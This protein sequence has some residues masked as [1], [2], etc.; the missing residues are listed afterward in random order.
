MTRSELVA[1]L[2]Q[3]HSHLTEREMR[4]IVATLF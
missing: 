1:R 4:V 3:A 2:I